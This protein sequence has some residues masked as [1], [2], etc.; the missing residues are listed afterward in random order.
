MTVLC[1]LSM[2]CISVV[3]TTGSRVVTVS[4]TWIIS[5]LILFRGLG[6]VGERSISLK[7]WK[8]SRKPCVLRIISFELSSVAM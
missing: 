2:R 5:A 1:A 7:S 8:Y 3:S 4:A 6:A